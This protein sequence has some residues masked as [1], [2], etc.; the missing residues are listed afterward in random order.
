MRRM[1]IVGCGDVGLRMVRS[2][3]GRWRI[4]ALTR[5]VDRCALLR[6]EGVIPV[7]GDLD[8]PESLERIAGLAQDV[9][10]LAPPPSSGAADPRT[11][12]LVRALSKRGSLPQRLV[13]LST[14]GVYGD[15][16]GAMVDETRRVMP[17]TDRARR[18]L[19]A[20]RR[21]RSWGA[22]SAV[23]VSILR[24]PG[25]YAAERLPLARL[26]RG[27]PA[28]VADQDPYTNHIHADDLARITIA[29]LIRG[30][31]GRIYNASDDSVLKMGEYFDLVAEHFS[32][33]P[34]PRVQ[35]GVALEDIPEPM[36]SFMRESR[37]LSNGRLKRE[38]RIRL[39]FPVVENGIRAAR[40][41]AGICQ[42]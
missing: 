25:I 9:M 10:H 13:Y 33:P 12:N 26:A 20:E 6:E 15:C 28:L 2:L 18:R 21:L 11:A 27:T 30:G 8:Y 29:A 34:P 41:A 24:T 39:Q 36:L 38:L 16:G 1:L 14:S 22:D 42:P 23:Q 40:M 17:G 3:K 31:G 35:W 37:R 4:F 32:L 7:M 5:S 19:D